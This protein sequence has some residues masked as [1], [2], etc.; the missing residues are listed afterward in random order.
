MTKPCN[1][2][3]E[4]KDGTQPPEFTTFVD[5][6]DHTTPQT[7]AYGVCHFALALTILS[8][9]KLAQLHTS[10][11]HHAINMSDALLQKQQVG[12]WAGASCKGHNHQFCKRVHSPACWFDTVDGL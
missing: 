3:S 11:H 4:T 6:G 2:L 10:S 7:N 5:I 12:D 8:K 9:K 1:L